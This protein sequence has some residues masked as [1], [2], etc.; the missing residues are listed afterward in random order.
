M[1]SLSGQRAEV[2][3]SEL[4]GR[5]VFLHLERVTSPNWQHLLPLWPKG[6]HFLSQQPEQNLERKERDCSRKQK[7][8]TCANSPGTTEHSS[9]S[10]SFMCHALLSNV[11]LP[12]FNAECFLSSAHVHS[13]LAGCKDFFTFTVTSLR[14]QAPEGSLRCTR[15]G[16]HYQIA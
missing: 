7:L 3:G 11:I 13:S 2:V 9:H 8:L 5:V 15:L 6:S 10:P 1:N 12:G 14:G 16:L 4:G